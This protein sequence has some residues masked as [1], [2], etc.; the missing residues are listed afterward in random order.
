MDNKIIK[1]SIS[2]A[3][4]IYFS[5]DV[6]VLYSILFINK[7]HQ[8]FSLFLQHISCYMLYDN[9]DAMIVQQPVE[10]T[11]SHKNPYMKKL[12]LNNFKNKSMRSTLHFICYL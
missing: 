6:I 3:S 8:F 11:F 10:I 1:N 4:S 2:N 9:A 7:F 12:F 5:K